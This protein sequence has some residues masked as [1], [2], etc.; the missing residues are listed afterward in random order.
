MM[1]KLIINVVSLFTLMTDPDR[2][3]WEQQ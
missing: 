3:H 2:V 1:K